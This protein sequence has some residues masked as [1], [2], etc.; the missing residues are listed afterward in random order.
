MSQLKLASALSRANL[1]VLID[2]G[3]A[4]GRSVAVG[5]MR[6]GALGLTGIWALDRQLAPSPV[7]SPVTSPASSPVLTTAMPPT[8]RDMP[9]LEIPTSAAILV[10]CL[11]QFHLSF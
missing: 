10:G 8:I 3:L 2:V 1:A 9:K 6:T 11:N 7:I 4:A 5:G